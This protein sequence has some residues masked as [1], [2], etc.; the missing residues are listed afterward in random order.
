MPGPSFPHISIVDIP[1]K[2]KGVI[3]NERIPRGTLII[4]EKPLIIMPA[5]NEMFD[6]LSRLTEADLLFL[7][8]FPCARDEDPIIGRFKH[9]TPCGDDV[10]GLCPTICRVNHTCYSPKASPNA[11]YIWNESAKE[12]ELRALKEIHEGQEIEV[13]Y[14]NNMANYEDPPIYLPKKFGFECS[15]KGCTRPLAERYASRQRIF[16]YNNFVLCLPLHFS[17]LPIVRNPLQ[18]LK[19][20]EMQIVIICEEGFTSEVGSRAHEAFELCTFY[21]DA[22]SA[23]QWEEICCDCYALYNGRNSEIFKTAQTLAAKPQDFPSWKR[24]GR[25]NLKGPSTQVLEYCYPTFETTPAVPN[26]ASSPRVGP[27]SAAQDPST[28]L[29]RGENVPSTSP[30]QKLSRGQKKNAKSKARKNA[31]RNT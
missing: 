24:L 31:A 20:L 30:P 5:N 21:G 16:A 28:S 18:V 25:R 14:T 13:S 8:S 23:R 19:D 27:T 29:A 3:A 17:M 2:G 26:E 10:F 9:F 7:L 4:S 11:V 1:G 22:T 12:E 6:A 15:C